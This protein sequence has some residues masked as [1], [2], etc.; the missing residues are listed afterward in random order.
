MKTESKLIS[1]S[2]TFCCFYFVAKQSQKI[3]NSI[4]FI[5]V[6]E[7]YILR[8]CFT[9]LSRETDAKYTS[10]TKTV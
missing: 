4:I 9:F 1:S 3:Y 2:T 6:K 5:T 7:Q 8:T 10:W